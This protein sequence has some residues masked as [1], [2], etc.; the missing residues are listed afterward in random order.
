[1]PVPPFPSSPHR[2]RVR[3]V[4]ALLAHLTAAVL[5]VAVVAGGLTLASPSARAAEPTDVVAFPDATLKAAVNRTL[6]GGRADD[7]DVTVAD[8]ARVT[9]IAGTRFS[10]AVADLTGLESLTGLTSFSMPTTVQGNTFTDLTPL[11]GLTGLTTLALPNGSVADLGPLAGL[12]ALRTLNL[13][14]NRVERLAPLSGLTALTA[15]ALTGNQVSDLEGIPT[16]P[17]LATLQLGGNRITDV[18]P[19]AG[20]FTSSVLT[21]VA[22]TGNR[23][24]DASPLAAYGDGGGRL[25]TNLPA[26]Q[27]LLLSQ[28][29]IADFSAFSGWTRP[30]A[31]ARVVGQTLYAGPYTGGGVRVSLRSADASAIEVQPL[32]TGAYDTDSGLL[33][34]TD[35]ASESLALFTATWNQG[36]TWTVVFTEDPDAPARP[37]TTML[38]VSGDRVESSALTLSATV[39]PADAAGTVEFRD[40]ASVLG[41]DE[42][43]SGT[44]SISSS[45]LAV[46]EHSL[47]AVYTPADEGR[48]TP[49]TSAAVP[50]TITTRPVGVAIPDANL[51]AALNAGLAR[52]L[53]TT[54]SATQDVTAADAVRLDTLNEGDF[55]AGPIGDLTGLEAFTNLLSLTSPP[56]LQEGH[57]FTD[58]SPLS[59][60]TKLRTLSLPHG[61]IADLTPLAGMTQLT[62]VHLVRNRVSDP[63]PLAGL[64]RL[65]LLDLGGNQVRDLSRV[66]ALPAL[67]TLLLQDNGIREPAP[68]VGKF[69]PD[70]LVTLNLSGNRIVDA[71]SLAPLGRDGALIGSQSAISSGLVLSGNRIADLSAFADWVNPQAVLL[72]SGQAV[73]VGRYRTGGIE[74]PLRAARATDV[75]TVSPAGAGSYDPATGL[76]T[77]TDPAAASVS[78]SSRRA[79][80][81]TWTVHFSLPPVEPGDDDGPRVTGVPQVGERLTV[82]DFGAVFAGTECPRYSVRWL[83]DGEAFPGNAHFARL[84]SSSS[85]DHLMGAP[86]TARSY[87]VSVTDLGH[88]L[89]ARVTCAAT[90]VSSTSAPLTVTSGQVGLPLVQ[91]LTGA[92]GYRVAAQ[93][94]A[95]TTDVQQAR[96]G[97]VGDP[98]NPTI[99]VHVAQLDAAGDLV[100]PARIQLALASVRSGTGDR[101]AV[102]AEDVRITGT[103]A[104]RTITVN[105][106]G[107]AAGVRLSFT[108]TGSTGTTSTF[109]LNYSASVATTPT[110]R[111]LMGSSDASTAI[112]VGDGHLL[113]ADDEKFDVRLYDATASGREVAHFP[114]G[115]LPPSGSGGTTEMDA[116]AS[117]RQGDRI[118]WL[119]SHGN[120]KD[121]EIQTSRHSIYETRLSGTGANAALV[122]TG[123]RYGGLRD[124]LIAWDNDHGARFG[125]QA[126]AANNQRPDPVDGFNIEGAEF[127]PDDSALYLG[128]RSPLVPKQP[129]G[130]ALI[131]PLTN[132]EALTAGTA[133]RARFGDPILLDLGG[134]SIR[135]IRKNARDEYLVLSAPAGPG[136]KNPAAQTL[137]AW[138]GEPDTAPRRL[139]TQLPVDVEPANTS[140]AGAWEGIGE[141]PERLVPGADVRLIMDQ[142]Y[143]VLYG[144]GE[145][146]DDT[147][148]WTNKART[149]VVTLAG[150]VGTRASLSDPGAFPD[151]AA[152]TV[153]APRTVTVTNAGSNVLRIGRVLTTDEDGVSASDFLTAGDTCTGVVLDPT[154][155]CVVRVRFA[156]SRE[157]VTSRAL[158]VVTSDVPGGIT[159][160]ALSGASRALPQGPAGEDGEDGADG[161]PGEAGQDGNDGVRGPQGPPGLTGPRG[162]AGTIGISAVTRTVRVRADRRVRL[163]FLVQNR[164]GGAVSAALRARTPASMRAVGD[165]SIRLRA[166]RA[167]KRTRIAF[168]L[169]VGPKAAAGRHRV[170]VTF[171]VGKAQVTRTVVVVVPRG[172]PGR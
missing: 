96:S 114:L 7:Q 136:P 161:R 74:V 146:K 73:Y 26:T 77:V 29:R 66:P 135:E 93:G 50:V 128:F 122:P 131:V 86:G 160:V 113:V 47:T 24:A 81:L 79:A 164:T 62:S 63:S 71:S 57:T 28:N 95:V 112:A 37:T 94:G 75:P 134:D 105:P 159:D 80:T 16:A 102:T 14:G 68:L 39:V 49:S 12:T 58:L 140:N 19:L 40:G 10:G 3:R 157:N 148:D 127:S 21:T 129:G 110:S 70:V 123:M 171:R 87:W 133:V 8:A 145:N 30:P 155:T 38:Q 109:E 35:P 97:V 99:P 69:A 118:W 61:A 33:T 144:S 48:F 152:T 82:E 120:N 124:D 103:G 172:R 107:S 55:P 42:V 91:G 163:P 18:A 84:N 117:A 139:S 45:A 165:R 100:D 6:G 53:Q 167:G 17:G 149:D 76:L 34:R 119:G 150:P 132:L 154:E 116:E 43:E 72:T 90:G 83:R 115:A 147:D 56:F 1:M 104:R 142:G 2:D 141:M 52:R 169:R 36:P 89:Q 44:A 85:T 170:R 125:L 41:S 5:A 20:R 88:Q 65:T 143:V 168:V 162:P 153:G 13:N 158:L 51:R 27:G 92:S 126:A 111:V 108:A 121:G 156:P 138:N 31:G 54:R 22:L 78:L 32:E 4:R 137:W 98:T 60:L 15:L 151:Q 166:L 9:T 67:T 64:T 59:A 25:G 23:I 130:E 46:G 101:D 11:A 106:Q